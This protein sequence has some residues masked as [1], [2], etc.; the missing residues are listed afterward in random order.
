MSAVP[1]WC[2]IAG[3]VASSTVGDVLL[4]R[5]MRQIGHVGELSRRHGLASVLKA[6]VTHPSLL[7]ALFFMATSFFGLLLALS[8]ADVS[9]VVPASASLTYV[10]NA[11]AAR[12]FLHERVDRRRW[13]SALLVCA[14][15]AVLAA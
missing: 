10:T 15:V 7:V 4:S 3:I 9:L 14:G 1:T 2:A 6:I 13:L 8:W 5:A 11:L 12:L